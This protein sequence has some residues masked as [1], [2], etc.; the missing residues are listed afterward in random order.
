MGEKSRFYIA[1]FLLFMIFIPI[2]SVAEDDET[3][4]WFTE[5]GNS[6]I[7]EQYTA[8]W[9]DVCAKIDP[10]IS[11]FADNRGS[12]IIRIALHDPVSDPLGDSI[13]NERLSNYDDALNLAPSFW[14]DSGNEIKGL[15]TPVDLNRALLNSEGIRES[16]TLI[17][18][19]VSEEITTDS[20]K[21]T[22]NYQPKGNI[23][24]SQASIFLLADMIIDESLATNGITHHQDV[25]RGYL[26]IDFQENQ[27]TDLVISDSNFNSG[28][29]NIS[30]VK[31]SNGYTINLNFL[32]VDEKIE[33]ISIV[34]AHEYT[35]DGERSTLGAVSIS[36]GE[37][38]NNEGVSIFV[39]ILLVTLLS[40]IIL[41]K[42]QSL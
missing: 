7:M 14:F 17:S 27:S 38:S 30:M 20:L 13:T 28:F 42:D 24:N 21:L 10:W 41:F 3:N 2:I 9:C 4:N 18:I 29:S 5:G 25:T 34:A 26:N 19:S 35:I 11:N 8:T 12:R 39:P 33:D 40:T 37:S 22:I 32:L 23:N 6:V 15:V 31:D 36:L 16:D 1:I